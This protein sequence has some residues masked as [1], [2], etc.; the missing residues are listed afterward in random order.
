MLFLA[1]RVGDVHSEIMVGKIPPFPD[2]DTANRGTFVPTPVQVASVRAGTDNVVV[3]FG[4]GPEFR[5][6]ARRESCVATGTGLVNETT[7]FYFASETYAG[8]PCAS[9]CSVTV[10][11]LPHRVLYYRV[12]YRAQ[13]GA[14]IAEGGTQIAVTP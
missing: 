2:E 10:P 4:Y 7:P 8:R 13:S 3:E 9:G 14:A 5:C 6:T 1:P 11:A 12:R